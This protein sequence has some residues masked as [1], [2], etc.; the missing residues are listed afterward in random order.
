MEILNLLILKEIRKVAVDE[1]APL[2]RIPDYF[3]K[4]WELSS[5]P[6]SEQDVV[7]PSYG[8]VEL[9]IER[10]R[11][12]NT[13]IPFSFYPQDAQELLRQIIVTEA[14]GVAQSEAENHFRDAYNAGYIAGRAAGEASAKVHHLSDIQVKQLMAE[15]PRRKFDFSWDG[16]KK[17]E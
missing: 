5:I 11:V 17:G 13:K 8:Y 7:A 16:K 15:R 9:P 3:L 14:T 4:S 6:L 10:L 12:G 2:F 1:N